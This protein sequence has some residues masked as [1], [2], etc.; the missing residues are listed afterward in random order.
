MNNKPKVDQTKNAESKV[1]K[2]KENWFMV[3][4]SSVKLAVIVI[5]LI[6]IS[7]ILGT[8]IV[9]G[10]TTQEYISMYGGG[11]TAFLEGAQ[12]TNVF[13]SYWFTILLVILC[14]NLVVCAVKRW[15]NTILQIGFL[16]THL[17]L[18]LIMA[19]CLIDGWLGVK[20]GINMIE[21][22]KVDYF[23][24]FPE[25]GEMKKVPLGFE[26][27]L[28][29]FELV[30][31]KPKF[32]LISY[33]KEI[34][35]ERSI[36]T[37]KGI[38]Q[39]IQSS[40]YKVK[41]KEFIPD[42]KLVREPINSP[43]DGSKNPAVFTQLF[44]SD[45]VDAEGWLIANAQNW[46]D[47]KKMEIRIEYYW[48]DTAEERDNL[49]NADSKAAKTTKTE[50]KPMVKVVLKDTNMEAEF[51]FVIG[52]HYPVADTE[53]HLQMV[54]YVP[55]F[56]NKDVPIEQQK[57]VNPAVRVNIHG[58]EGDETRWIFANYPDWDSIHAT[59]Y[60]NIGLTFEAGGAVKLLRHVVKVIHSAD[61]IN[62]FLYLRD[63]NIIENKGWELD[64]KYN[65]GDSGYQLKLLKYYPNF[66][67]KEKMLQKSDEEINPAI[68][69]EMDG[70]RGTSKSEWLFA[71][72]ARVWWYDDMNFAILY[73]EQAEMIKDF[74]SKLQV[75]DNGITVK[76][77]VIE[78]ND[79]LSYKGIDFYQA[80]YDPD[81][82][83]FS[84]LQ[85]TSHPG[86]P[87][88]FSGFW[89]LV[90]GIVFIFYIKPL[91]KRIRKK[92]GEVVNA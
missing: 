52:K 20:G 24:T 44:G 22:Q 6:A 60:T 78:V 46:Y 77:K 69:V 90:F 25:E 83:K 18:I 53:Y 73:K 14:I 29:D 33:V 47:D 68:L 30:K 13:H 26:L 82:P 62:K 12:F 91:I 40:P 80:N 10:R 4:F 49:M 65:I 9:Q 67:I 63:G 86:I 92:K 72:D 28:E 66:K 42:A 84:G 54:E 35:K 3:L 74:K 19:G 32:E 71:K 31:H 43:P 21:G 79:Y 51:P 88:V 48:A 64:K 39:S 58:P 59:K 36:S 75:I 16:S 8:F 2:K 15:R 87:V 81:N 5:F 50:S 38:V 34:D 70:P 17:S 85:I 37:E 7:C 27:L 41:I 23:F 11:W 1:S 56:T 45:Q 76:T 55:D 89:I 61:G 57:P